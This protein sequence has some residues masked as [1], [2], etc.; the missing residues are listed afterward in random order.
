[1]EVNCETKLDVIAQW[2]RGSRRVVIFTGAGVST[3]SGIPDFRSPGGLWDRFDPNEFLF[4]K[5]LASR[6]VRVN[7]W[8]LHTE[9]Y[10]TILKAEV[11][12]AHRACVE[13][14]RHGVLD[15]VI[16]QNIDGL[17][18]KAGLPHEKVI[19]LH[20]N[21]MKVVCLDCGLT[22]DRG[23]IQQR[24][25]N[26]DVAPVCDSCGGLLKPATVA[27]GQPMPYQETLEAENRSR[28]ADVFLAIGSSLVVYPAAYMPLHAKQ[29]G[30]K[31]VIIN[32]S[33]TPYDD[34]ADIIVEGKAGEAMDGLLKR[35]YP[36]AGHDRNK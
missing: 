34:I 6:E 19:E 22:C 36:E 8:K 33:S 30:A 9:I 24:I 3:E 26:G 32:L 16:T 15:C 7:Y 31:L 20:G 4:Q 12:A 10:Y 28:Q 23:L 25:E 27:F 35:V 17:H 5:F 18:Q 14:E 21:A 13:L 1:M 2:I 29:A 11:N